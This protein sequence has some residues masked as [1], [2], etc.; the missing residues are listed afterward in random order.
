LRDGLSGLAVP[1]RDYSGVVL[2]ALG[3]SG[4]CEMLEDPSHT[5]VPGDSASCFAAVA[6]QFATLHPSTHPRTQAE[7]TC[8]QA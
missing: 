7:A 3:V 2:G 1:V 6:R 8:E 5:R 4:P